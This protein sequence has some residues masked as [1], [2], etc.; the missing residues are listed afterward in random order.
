M[1][2]ACSSQSGCCRVP[3][4]RSR[5]GPAEEITTNVFLMDMRLDFFIRRLAQINVV[6][7]LCQT[8]ASHRDALQFLIS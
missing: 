6:G 7:R 1:N 8:P 3:F 5:F 4:D 2:A